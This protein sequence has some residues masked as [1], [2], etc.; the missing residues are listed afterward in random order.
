MVVIGVGNLLMRDDGFGVHVVRELEDDESFRDVEVVDAMTSTGLVLEAMANRDRA[1]IL[2]AISIEGS[3]PGE[4]HTFRFDPHSDSFPAA[5][6]TSVHDVHFKEVIVS[7]SDTYNLPSEI[8]VV[9]PEPDTVSPGMELSDPCQRAV[10]KV[11][12]I[13]RHEHGLEPST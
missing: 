8:L 12:E 10:P 1:T 2:D 7:G 6:K 3:E 13:V 11:I 4:V 5:V 9:G